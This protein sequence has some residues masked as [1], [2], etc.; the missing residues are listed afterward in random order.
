MYRSNFSTFSAFQNLLWPCWSHVIR[1]GWTGWT[2]GSIVD[3]KFPGHETQCSYSCFVSCAFNCVGNISAISWLVQ[4][5]ERKSSLLHFKKSRGEIL[6]FCVFWKISETKLELL[7]S[8]HKHMV[9]FTESHLEFPLGMIWK[10][11]IQ[12]LILL[13]HYN[14]LTSIAF[15]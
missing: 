13:P 6:G 1:H 7:L 11:K 14:S 10:R 5:E 15:C 12:Y 3:G 4:R 9:I 8:T 2:P